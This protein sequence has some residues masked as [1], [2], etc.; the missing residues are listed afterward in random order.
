MKLSKVFSPRYLVQSL[1]SVQLGVRNAVVAGNVA[2]VAPLFVG[3]RSAEQ[4]LSIHRR[5]YQASLTRALLDKFPATVWLAGSTFVTEAARMFV[6]EYPPTTPCIAEYGESFPSFLGN[7]QS[8]DR[9]PYLQAF[10]E[11]EWHIGH[12]AIAVDK[13]SASIEKLRSVPADL[14]PDVGLIM[15]TGVRYL[16][17]SWPVDE[18][19]K[20]YLAETR[21]ELLDFAPAEVNIEIHGSRGE[22]SFCRL[23]TADYTF[24]RFV[25]KGRSIGESAEEALETDSR[26]DVGTAL[27]ALFTAGLVAAVEHRGAGI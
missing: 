8:A 22:F 23:D 24:R 18:L 1:A 7:R 6:A 17:A 21:P 25:S 20:I 14:L 19:L 10:A 9:T 3:G 27:V 16:M 5:H 4:R 13:P 15:Q 11:L 12:V 26:F 2:P